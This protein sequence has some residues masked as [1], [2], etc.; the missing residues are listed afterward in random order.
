MA[1]QLAQRA[2]ELLD[3]PRSYTGI[4]QV[5]KRHRAELR[6]ECQNPFAIT[7]VNHPVWGVNDEGY[8]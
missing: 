5:G 8:L 1:C 3:A 7:H 2:G 6:S 4:A